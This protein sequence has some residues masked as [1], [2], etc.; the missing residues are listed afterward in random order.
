MKIKYI[1]KRLLIAIPTFIGI[2]LLSYLLSSLAPGS[3]LDAL[4]ADPK[5]TTIELERRRVEL[6]L[7]QSVMVQYFS[8]FNQLLH[9]NL[10][11]SFGSN[12]LPV[13][14]LIS[15]R[16]KPT[17]LLAGSSFLFSILVAIPLGVIAASKPNS[18][19]DY[20]SS[21]ISFLM[22]GTPNFFAGLALIYIFGVVLKILPTGGMYDSS[23]DK[24]TADL[25]RHMILPMLVLSFQQ[26]GAWI[27]YMRSSMLEVFQEDYLRTARAKG[28]RPFAVIRKHAFKNSLLPVITV[29]GMSIPGLVG[30]AVV[31]EQVFSWPGIG[32]LM[33]Q[34][35]AS[36]DY[37][38]IMGITVLV[39]TVVLIVNLITDLIYGILDP[40]ISYQ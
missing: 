33:I 15:E 40:R 14:L 29:I 25:L 12:R 13:A 19:R 8:W 26:I 39:A 32:S 27:R 38:V 17:L 20:A 5:I 35:I 7:D 4:L 37:P 16:L 9:G 2:T 3:P 36:R 21:G 30:G 31:T 23:G 11:Y 34:S 24:T 22:V 6:G 10:G 1:L 18:M 28:L